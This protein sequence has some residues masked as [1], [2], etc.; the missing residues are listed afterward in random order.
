[1]TM[2]HRAFL[3]HSSTDKEFVRA[4][5]N[6]LGR[7][8]C[9]FDEQV[10]EDGEQFKEAIETMLDESS[11]FVLFI[12]EATLERI[13]VKFE[14]TEAWYRILESK[15]SKSLVFLLSPS[16][17]FVDLPK[18]LSR[19]KIS[20]VTSAKATAREVRHHLDEMLRSQQQSYFEG[21]TADIANLQKLLTPLGSPPPRIVGVYGLPSVGRRT[22]VQKAVQLS[23]S[24]PKTLVVKIAEGDTLADI[25]IKIANLLEPFSTKE[26]FESIIDSIRQ[27]DEIELLER[28]V[29]N[30]SAATN[31]K[32]LPVLLDEGGLLTPDGSLADPIQ[33]IVSRLEVEED[34][35]LFFVS[36]RKPPSEIASMNLRPLADDDTQRLIA[37][38]ADTE[39]VAMTASQIKEIAEYVHGY[40]PCAYYAVNQAKEYGV[41]SVVMDKSRLVQFRTS[42]FVKFL[43]E[44]QLG[45]N[46]KAILMLL[47]RYSPAPAQVMLKSLQVDEITLFKDL[48]ALID[49]SLVV[50]DQNGL[51]EIAGPVS[52]AVLSQFRDDAEIN[53]DLVFTAF[54]EILDTAEEEL[55][56]LELYR[57][58]FKAALRTGAN[59]D[60][61]FH[62]TS[63]LISFAKDFYH[64]REYKQCI[65]AARLAVAESPTSVSGRDYLIRALIQE[66]IWP[67]A[68]AELKTF[69][70]YAPVRD[71]HFLNGFYHRKAGR[72][73]TALLE[74]QLAEKHDR[75]GVSLYR[76]IANCYFLLGDL[77]SAKRYIQ[78]G[79]K[80]KENRFLVDLKIQI[81]IKEKQEQEAREG[82]AQLE[83]IDSKAFVCHRVS[84]VELRFGSGKD[85]LRAAEEAI[86]VVDG[87]PPFGM[88]AQLISCQIRE[89]RYPEADTALQRLNRIY[90]NQKND[91]RLGLE[92]RLEIERKRYSKALVIFSRIQDASAPVYK[93]MK[94]DALEGILSSVLKDIERKEYS[95][96]LAKLN[97]Q[98][99]D[100][101]DTGAWLSLVQ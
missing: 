28:N 66:G 37:K 15:I 33:K 84:T 90:G 83:V 45:E 101:D 86:E 26:G 41:Q 40:P 63:D 98:L 68:E 27:Q 49:H 73:K 4:V 50:P 53:H 1:M 57:Q 30:L 29:A 94:R 32:E 35:Y 34:I 72:L 48:M 75:R 92:C 99:Q 91:I 51:Y 70:A 65:D 74:L 6:E 47:A 64:R 19:A 67:E 71:Y 89:G 93:L 96:E 76:E 69:G 2:L 20:N 5:A 55:P 62:M 25:S 42:A 23:L 52:D 7:Q 18:W 31:H 38:V 77:P 24:Y 36:N 3:S 100:F 14:I 11:A 46:Q 58:L 60:D 39:K 78:N 22:F 81:A 16:I 10:F 13:W 79:L 61:V 80:L 44:K 17:Q 8:F 95:A 21:R 87:R 85:A 59:K 56:R 12:S 43:K 9:L 54:K 97:S 82:L 88:L